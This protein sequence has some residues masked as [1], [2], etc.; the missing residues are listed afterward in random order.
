M[1][2]LNNSLGAAMQLSGAIGVAVVDLE[3]GMCLAQAGGGEALNLDIAAA[4][5]TEVVKEKM[6]TM[7][8]LGLED[9]IEDI[10]ITLGT[11]YHIIRP[12]KG[13]GAA[14]LFMYLAIDRQR[15]NLAMARHKLNEIGRELI[16]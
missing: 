14:G 1:A 8:Q 5:N 13:K 6:N 11:Q 2:N 16:V 4:G 15:G 12:L 9:E 3:S 10:L 7:R